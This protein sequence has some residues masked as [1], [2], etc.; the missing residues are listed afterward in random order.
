MAVI[1][2]VISVAFFTYLSAC[3]AVILL[4]WR[5]R[6]AF[7][8]QMSW[9]LRP[10]GTALEWFGLGVAICITLVMLLLPWSMTTYVAGADYGPLGKTLLY[11]TY[12]SMAAWVAYL[13][14][15]YSTPR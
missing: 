10:P 3:V 1:V 6:P 5:D 7:L 2:G 8:R 9:M 13:V 15:I 12:V 4:G 14:R 11:A